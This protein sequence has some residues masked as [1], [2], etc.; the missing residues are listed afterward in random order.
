M[1]VF[2]AW[3]YHTR[4]HTHTNTH[5]NTLT[6]THAFPPTHTQT[7]T[8]AQTSHIH[9][10]KHGGREGGREIVKQAGETPYCMHIIAA[11]LWRRPAVLEQEV[12]FLKR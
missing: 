4:K 12:R 1:Q 5:T 3:G 6:H 10:H 2:G 7:H 8:H 9:T 11:Q